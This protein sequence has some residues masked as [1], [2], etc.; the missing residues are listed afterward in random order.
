MPTY[1]YQCQRCEA[2]YDLY[3]SFSAA[4]RHR[5][6][7]C[8]RGMAQ[9]VLHPPTIVFKGSGFYA[10]DSRKGAGDAAVSEPASKPG[11]EAEPAAKSEVK[12]EAPAA[13]APKSTPKGK[14][15]SEPAKTA[16]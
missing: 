14:K 4:A 12:S 1:E 11:K 7:Q 10:T 5:C 6:R 16:S 9:R 2:S 13:G 8:R 15:K 3:E